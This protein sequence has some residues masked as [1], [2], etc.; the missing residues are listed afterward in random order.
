MS[1]DEA[2]VLLQSAKDAKDDR[3]GL[4][5]D[6]FANLIFSTDEH[7]AV[8]LQKLSPLTSK[9]PTYTQ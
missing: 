9:A 5:A 2:Q 8:D 4:N 6:E 7:L 3:T 1:I